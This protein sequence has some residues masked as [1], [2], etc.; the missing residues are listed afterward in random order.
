MMSASQ[1]NQ[2]RILVADDEQA[3]L[4]LYLKVFSSE[5]NDQEIVIEMEALED[6]LF[7]EPVTSP[8][9]QVFDLVLCRQGYEAVEEK[10]KF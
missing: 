7:G 3:I 10:M 8:S 2:V 9:I 6:K 4:E 1:P 5:K